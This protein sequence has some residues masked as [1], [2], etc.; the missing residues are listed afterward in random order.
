MD[1]EKEEDTTLGE[2]EVSSFKEVWHQVAG[3]KDHG[4]APGLN[5]CILNFCIK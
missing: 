4:D 3:H 2:E 1:L 5:H